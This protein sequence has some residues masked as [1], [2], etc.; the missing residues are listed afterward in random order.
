MKTER[1]RSARRRHRRPQL[2]GTVGPVIAQYRDPGVVCG[3]RRQN[4]FLWLEGSL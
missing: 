3:S 1:S 2:G 4:A